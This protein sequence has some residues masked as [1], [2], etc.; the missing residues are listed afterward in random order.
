MIDPFLMIYVFLVQKQ[1][2]KIEEVPEEF[3]N[4]VSQIIHNTE[5]S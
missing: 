1:L 4:T 3:R 5:E 2:Y